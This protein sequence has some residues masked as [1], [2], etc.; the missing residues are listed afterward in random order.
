MNGLTMEPDS[1]I[2][3][4]LFESPRRHGVTGGREVGSLGPL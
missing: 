2:N 4:L 1:E 3:S